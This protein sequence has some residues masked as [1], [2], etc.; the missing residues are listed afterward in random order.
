MPYIDRQSASVCRSL[1]LCV[2]ALI[3]A[4][5]QPNTTFIHSLDWHMQTT[6]GVNTRLRASARTQQRYSPHLDFLPHSCTV[7]GHVLDLFSHLL[8]HLMLT[9]ALHDFCCCCYYYLP[10]L[11]HIYDFLMTLAVM[12]CYICMPATVRC[13]ICTYIQTYE[14]I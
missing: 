2:G 8:S 7:G 12:I 9:F 5:K 4:S 10:F 1:V 6:F 11:L 14:C 3:T 13:H